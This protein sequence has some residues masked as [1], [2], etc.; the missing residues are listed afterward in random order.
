MCTALVRAKRRVDNKPAASWPQLVGVRM[1]GGYWGDAPT[2]W[3]R[4]LSILCCTCY[5]D[6]SR[7]WAL[8][9]VFPTT[10]KIMTKAQSVLQTSHISSSLQWISLVLQTQY[11]WGKQ[12]WEF[13]NP[14]LQV[15]AECLRWLG[16]WER[17][18]HQKQFPSLYW[19][20]SSGL[21][22][23]GTLRAKKC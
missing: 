15:C 16:S 6:F 5:V 11:I 7:T 3:V 20:T 22:Y 9:W 10:G 8:T 4:L 21:H 14:E 12:K 1:Q 13:S 23:T 18:M 17:K 19:E 2:S